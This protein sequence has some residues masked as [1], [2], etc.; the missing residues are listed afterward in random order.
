M[1]KFIAVAMGSVVALVGFA[2]AAN[3][4]A[5]V[6]LIWI[7]ISDVDTNGIP[8]CLRPLNR[9]C[10]QLGTTLTSVAVTDTITLA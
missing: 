3:A 10:P 5:T 4:S 7:D 1:R 9:D 2:G 8:I 6:D